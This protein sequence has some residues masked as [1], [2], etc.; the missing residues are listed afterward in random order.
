M[1]IC[2]CGSCQS[3][4]ERASSLVKK[5]MADN[6]CPI[7]AFAVSEAMQMFSSYLLMEMTAAQTGL[8]QMVALVINHDMEESLR[9][10]MV[11]YMRDNSEQYTSILI[12]LCLAYNDMVDR[13]VAD[14]KA[15]K[16]D[17]PNINTPK[18]G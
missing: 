16:E 10:R 7:Y 13:T 11:Q 4:S 2:N 12:E 8:G 17:L 3:A 1:K 6:E 14:R 9:A 18:G 5:M 15:R